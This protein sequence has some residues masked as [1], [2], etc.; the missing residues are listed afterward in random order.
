MFIY[1]PDGT[2]VDALGSVLEKQQ[3][4]TSRL[5]DLFMLVSEISATS[6]DHMDR[7]ERRVDALERL[8]HEAPKRD[9]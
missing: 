5:E 1:D 4:L 7:L 6:N 8:I 9:D 2:C 3:A